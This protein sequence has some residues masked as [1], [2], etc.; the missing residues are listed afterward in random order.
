MALSSAHF[1]KRAELCLRLSLFSSDQ[2]EAV[3][4][5]AKARSY[6][7][8]ADAMEA[9]SLDGAERERNGRSCEGDEDENAP[10]PG[11]LEGATVTAR[12]HSFR[13]R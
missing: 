1:R 8:W 12:L 9:E 6:R 13:P 11:G 4:L 3:C 7:A 5:L 2:E 10:Q